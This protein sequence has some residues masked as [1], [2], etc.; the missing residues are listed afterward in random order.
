MQPRRERL[1]SVVVLALLIATGCDSGPRSPITPTEPGPPPTTPA[2]PAMPPPALPSFDASLSSASIVIEDAFA[3]VHPDGNRFGYE[4]RFL[5]RETSGRSAA[6]ITEVTVY[7]PEGSDIT[8][9]G[10]WR[11]TVQVKAGGSLDLFH[12][13]AGQRHLVY[14]APG[15]G[16]QTR[17]PNLTVAVSFVDANGQP[18]TVGASVAVR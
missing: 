7:G 16:G 8:G 12:T 11:E 2:P 5:L 10:C 3:K 17:T 1:A 18:G 4:V 15:S 13:D 6:T 9:P 14:C